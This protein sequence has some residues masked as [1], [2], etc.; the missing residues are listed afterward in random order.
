MSNILY[1][2]N[3]DSCHQLLPPLKMANLLRFFYADRE[4]HVISQLFKFSPECERTW[5]NLT[6]DKFSRRAFQFCYL[7]KL[8]FNIMSAGPDC[9]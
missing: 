1:N 3:S 4:I 5:V 6:T 8:C 9:N 2:S 7:C